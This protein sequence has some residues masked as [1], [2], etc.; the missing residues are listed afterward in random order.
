MAKTLLQLQ[1][2]LDSLEDALFSGKKKIKYADQ[3][4]EYVS[5]TEMKTARSILKNQISKMNKKSNTKRIKP[6]VGNDL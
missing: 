2:Q 5:I 3:E 6:V 4:I 1:T